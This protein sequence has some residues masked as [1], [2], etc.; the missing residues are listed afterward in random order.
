[1]KDQKYPM[2]AGG[3]GRPL[4]QRGTS[5]EDH[6]GTRRVVANN[7]CEPC[8]RVERR[9]KAEGRPPLDPGAGET[10]PFTDEELSWM[11]AHAS[12]YTL[13]RRQFRDLRQVL[14]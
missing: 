6:P 4:R 2:C 3:C 12:G 13:W 7:K 11:P 1:M 10:R 5:K 14:S 9:V 8:Y